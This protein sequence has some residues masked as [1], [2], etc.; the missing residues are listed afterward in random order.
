MKLI[1]IGFGSANFRERTLER[2][3]R[4]HPLSAMQKLVQRA[5]K[6]WREPLLNATALKVIYNAE[7]EFAQFLCI[8]HLYAA[9]M[10]N[11]FN[12]IFGGAY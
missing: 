1:E 12:R 6:V 10:S 8:W 11:D 2:S 3:Q 9:R 5:A 4:M 7:D